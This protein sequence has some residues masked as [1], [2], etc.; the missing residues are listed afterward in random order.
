MVNRSKTQIRFE[1]SPA[2]GQTWAFQTCSIP[3]RYSVCAWADIIVGFVDRTEGNA[4]PDCDH[5]T[6]HDIVHESYALVLWYKP[7]ATK[8][9]SR[10]KQ[11]PQR[12]FWVLHGVGSVRPRSHSIFISEGGGSSFSPTAL[13]VLNL[14]IPSG[15][16]PHSLTGR[17]W[18]FCRRQLVT[19]NTR[20]L[21]EIQETVPPLAARGYC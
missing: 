14:F 1:D 7:T 13:T 19:V 11:R 4:R 2:G 5:R 18:I 8:I 6:P 20:V 16:A 10:A 21:W 17:P 9:F 15:T 3:F 12:G